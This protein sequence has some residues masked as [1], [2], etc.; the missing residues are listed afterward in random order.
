M[1][2]I[3]DRE[4]DRPLGGLREES[5]RTLAPVSDGLHAAGDHLLRKAARAVASGD[6]KRACR[7]IERALD[8][9]FDEHERIGPAWLSASMLIFTAINDRLDTCPEDD[10]SWLTAA[11]QVL[12]RC[13]PAAAPALLGS[14]AAI[15]GDRSLPRA[16]ARRCRRLVGDASADAWDEHEPVERHVRYGAVRSV[17]S[18]V[19]D[20][21][22]QV[23]PR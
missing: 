20:Y 17:V 1:L 10:D 18:A 11:E 12:Q 15:V 3:L 2:R 21:Q 4:R 6:E 13:G 14:L 19:V 7:F 23:P 8:P 5:N 16:Q 22:R 9:P